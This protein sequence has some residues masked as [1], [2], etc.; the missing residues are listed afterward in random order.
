MSGIYKVLREIGISF[1]EYT[2]PA[3]FTVDEAEKYDRGDA[4][5]SKNLFLRNKKG[6]THYLVVMEGLKRANIRD[7]ERR[8]NETNLS[9]ASAERLMRY[10]GVTPGSVSPFALINDTHNEVQVIVD[11]GLLR[12]QKQGFHPNSNTATLI[13]STADF[14]KFLSWTGNR[15]TYLHL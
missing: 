12:S 13:L 4:I 7:L 5:H 6:D 2:H 15:I 9:F 10:L 14:R 8:L 3:V 1:E 11:E